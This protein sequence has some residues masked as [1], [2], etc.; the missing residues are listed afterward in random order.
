MIQ[1]GIMFVL[2]VAIFKGA[3]ANGR[4][5]AVYVLAMIVLAL[6]GDFVATYGAATLFWRAGAEDGQI[7]SAIMTAVVL[8]P[9]A[10]TLLG[11]GIA[12]SLATTEG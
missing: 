9:I 7:S 5:G 1:M 12:Y 3:R 10:G 2:G 11:G 4:S 8:M 6:I